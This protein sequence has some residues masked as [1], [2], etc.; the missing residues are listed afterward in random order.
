MQLSY[1]QSSRV[2]GAGL[3]AL[4]ILPSLAFAQSGLGTAA[5]YAVLA[6]S[7]ITNTGA[8]AISGDVGLSPALITG[9]PVGSPPRVRFTPVI[10]PRLRP[11]RISPPCMASLWVSP[12]PFR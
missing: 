9:L 1:K 11:R 8:T 7:T 10:P 12:A 4:L 5:S 2:T 6:G 3:A